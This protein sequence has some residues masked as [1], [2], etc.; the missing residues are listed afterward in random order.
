MF[1]GSLYAKESSTETPINEPRVVPASR[2]MGI[3]NIHLLK[4]IFILM[5]VE[6]NAGHSDRAA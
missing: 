3:R 5:E 6:V 2:L 4:K 1:S